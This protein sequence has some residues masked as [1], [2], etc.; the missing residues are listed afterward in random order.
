MTENEVPN[1]VTLKAMED[2]ENEIGMSCVFSSVDE[3]MVALNEEIIEETEKAQDIKKQSVPRKNIE[4]LFSGFD[5][6]YEPVEMNWGE[7]VGEE[8]W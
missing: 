3:M 1:A 6:E 8:V 2:A 4:K 5:G 7:P